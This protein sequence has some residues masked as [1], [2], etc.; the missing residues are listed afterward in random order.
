MRGEDSHERLM[1]LL[2]EQQNLLI[3]RISR[4]NAS[5]ES[6]PGGYMHIAGQVVGF[7]TAIAIVRSCL[8]G[9]P[10]VED[11]GRVVDAYEC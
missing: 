1:R 5:A 6:V 9:E 8:F 2:R 11:R 3:E 4:G 7:D 10:L